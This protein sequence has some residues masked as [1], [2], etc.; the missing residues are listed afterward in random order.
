MN[1]IEIADENVIARM[2]SEAMTTNP[3]A[4]RYATV[5]EAFEELDKQE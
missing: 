4:P 5:D 1:N 2:E 3:T